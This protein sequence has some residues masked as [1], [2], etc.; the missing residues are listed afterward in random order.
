MSSTVP[1]GIDV[2][3]RREAT[4][5]IVLA[6]L[7]NVW[8]HAAPSPVELRATVQRNKVLLHVEDRG[9]GIPGPL[10]SRVFE[11]GARAGHSIG[12]GHSLA[13]ARRLMAEQGGAITFRARPGGGT[14]F[15]LHFQRRPSRARPP[16]GPA[17]LP[18]PSMTGR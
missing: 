3:G 18:H 7:D 9:P 4:A 15:T 1:R 13:T 6:L 2:L 14:T 12:S 10:R 11:P 16:R 5:A 8:H 17:P